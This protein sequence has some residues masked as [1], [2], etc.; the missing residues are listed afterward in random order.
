[1]PTRRLL[2]GFSPSSM[3]KVRSR[4]CSRA[5]SSRCSTRLGV[6]GGLAPAGPRHSRHHCG[7]QGPACPGKT[8]ESLHQDTRYPGGPPRHRGSDLRGRA[9]ERDLAPPWQRILDLGARPQ[10]L[11]WASTGTKDPSPS[12]L[13]YIEA[14]AAPY[15]VNTMPDGTLNALAD[16]GE[17]DHILPAHGGDCEEVL[18]RFAKADI[19]IDALARELQD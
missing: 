2:P 9:C 7:G 6:A 10:R 13:L 14:L 17:I 4:W 19:D 12:D 18:T 5:R 8:P 3:E 11:L 16:H 15:T 1:M